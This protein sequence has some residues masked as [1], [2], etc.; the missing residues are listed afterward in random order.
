MKKLNRFVTESLL[1]DEEELI[2]R[3]NLDEIP[4]TGIKH[5]DIKID[6][7]NANMQAPIVYKYADELIELSKKF[8]KFI[9][10]NKLDSRNII[11]SNF[12]RGAQVIADANL[13]SRI[14]PLDM[15][16]KIDTFRAAIEFFKQIQTSSL[17]TIKYFVN[18]F[19][20]LE[21]TYL[22]SISKIKY[23]ENNTFLSWELYNDKIDVDKLVSEMK[24]LKIKTKVKIDIYSR[25]TS[26]SKIINVIFYK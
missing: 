10:D 15:M 5:I 23:G 22:G 21:D 20:Y 6:I 3:A 2:N 7:M 26:D 12:I 18:D 14:N 17:S 24:K 13:D 1:G 25:N 8:I 19:A 16:D 4:H 9:E 11:S